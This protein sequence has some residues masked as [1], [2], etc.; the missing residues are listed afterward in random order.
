[1]SLLFIPA[2]RIIVLDT[3]EI[4]AQTIYSRWVDWAADNLEHPP[5]F[6]QVGG[7]D[8]GGGL[9][10][11]P[12]FFLLNGWRVRPMESNHSLN[13]VGNMYVEEGGSPVVSTV[14]SFRVLVQLTVPVQAQSFT[15]SG[16]G[17]SSGTYP[18]PQ[19][20]RQ[21]IDSNSTQLAAIRNDIADVPAQVRT[22]LTPE[23]AKIM[24]LEANAGLTSA[25]ATMILEMYELLG[26]DPT[27]PLVV[28][29]SGR[30]AG[31]ISQSIATNA[32]QT[33]VRRV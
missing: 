19:Q 21:E 2:E 6:R 13:I 15:V 1:M 5:A 29:T 33:T 20:I 26:L 14:G 18:T 31:D 17:G 12:Y 27:K 23:L 25:Q 28:T 8:L 10:I 30:F 32:N 7:D 9:L 16:T 4:S 11:P 3:T 24:T 22:E